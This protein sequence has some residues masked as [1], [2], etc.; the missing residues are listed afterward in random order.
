M[1]LL[2]AGGSQL[3]ELNE[4]YRRLADLRNIRTLAC[5]EKYKTKNAALIVTKESAD[6]GI[7]DAVPIP[8]DADHLSICKPP[9]RNAP[10]YRSVL[11]R[12]G[13]CFPI[14]EDD[15][16]P[17]AL[18]GYEDAATRDRRDLQQ[19]LIDAGREHEYSFANERQNKFAQRYLRFGLHTAGRTANEE[20][21]AAVEQ[22]FTMHVFHG[23]ICQGASREEVDDAIQKHVVEP[24]CG[25][26]YGGVIANAVT[27][28]SALYYLADR[29]YIRWDGP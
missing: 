21:L 14:V 10:I 29:C 27:V 19:K 8:F 6:P 23:R 24:I 13:Q 22:R 12:V 25:Q 2:R 4:A 28:M 15:V 20:L 17:F 16:T 26:Q 11:R 9:D 5:Y 1:E 3:D 18:D 7:P